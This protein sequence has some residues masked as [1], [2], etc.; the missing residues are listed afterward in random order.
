MKKVRVGK[1]SFSDPCWANISDKGKD[2]ISQLLTYDPDKRPSA[3]QALKHPWIS[4]MS[5]G[6]LDTAIAMG[7]LTNLKTFRA[8]QKLN[9]LIASGTSPA[10]VITAATNHAV[11]LMA[12]AAEMETGRPAKQVVDAARPP[13]FWKRKDSLVRQLAAWR[14]STLDSALEQL[15]EAELGMRNIPALADAIGSRTLL[16]LASRAKRERRATF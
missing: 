5:S 13:V 12:F 11:R 8:D 15:R 14:L 10:G 3:E 16:S 9:R 6:P 7:A 4:E 1:F 2:L